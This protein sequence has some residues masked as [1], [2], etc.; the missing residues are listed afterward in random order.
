[1]NDPFGAI[2]AVVMFALLVTFLIFTYINK[3]EY[4]EALKHQ[5]YYDCM[6]RLEGIRVLPQTTSDFC[7]VVAE[8]KSRIKED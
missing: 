8:E 2:V 3:D 1:M 6:K 4:D 5:Y 7:M